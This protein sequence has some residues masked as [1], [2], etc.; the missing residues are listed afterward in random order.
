M[1][2]WGDYSDEND[3]TYDAL[4]LSVAHRLVGAQ[5]EPH[6]REAAGREFAKSVVVH[7][8]D[9]LPGVVRWGL[10][11]GLRVG[12]PALRRAASMLKKELKALD[13]GENE[14]DWN[15]PKSRVRSIK[16]E[17]KAIDYALQNDG[18][19]RKGKVRGIASALQRAAERKVERVPP[20]SR[21]IALGRV[22]LGPWPMDDPPRATLPRR[23]KKPCRP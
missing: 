3:N 8:G 21:A 16:S 13:S 4:G 6:E 2:A 14:R 9:A 22:G 15:D 10:L 23:R 7:A 11:N 19:G 17:L 20:G 1:G 18:F 5:I 12:G